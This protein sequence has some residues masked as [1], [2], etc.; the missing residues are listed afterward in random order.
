MT[1]VYRNLVGISLV[2]SRNFKTGS[3]LHQGWV[4]GAAEETEAGLLHRGG[5]H[6]SSLE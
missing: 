5:L 2:L 1:G 4:L 3:D 6:D